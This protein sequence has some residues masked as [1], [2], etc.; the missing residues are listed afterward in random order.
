MREEQQLLDLAI[1]ADEHIMVVDAKGIIMRVNQPWMDFCIEHQI[2][3]ELWKAGS[4]YFSFLEKMGLKSELAVFQQILNNEKDEHRQLYPFHLKNG[5]TQW[6]SVKVRPIKKDNDQVQGIFFS[7]KPVT[8]HTMEPI[9]A[10]SVL[11]SMTDGFYLLDD[12][13]K[14]NYIND[15]AAQLLSCKRENVIGQ[16]VFEAF[17]EIRGSVF[18]KEYT[19]ALKFKSKAEIEEYY[20]PLDM[21]VSKKVYP[22]KRGGL[23]VYF[24]DITERKKA[25]EQLKEF[26]YYDYLTGV[27]NRRLIM[28]KASSYIEKGEKFSFFYI[29]LDNLKFVNALYTYSA[30]DTV[31]KSVAKKL[32]TLNS[33]KCEIG[34]L[35]GDEFCVLYRPFKEERLEGFAAR[36]KELFEEPFVLEGSQTVRINAS[37]GISCYPFDAKKMDELVSFSQ[38]AMYEAKKIHGSSSAFFRPW[39]RE[40]RERTSKIEEGLSGNLDAV[41][42]EFAVQPQIDGATGNLS[43]IEVLSRWHHPE[44]GFISP[45][46]F[47][48]IAEQT[49]TIASLTTHLLNKVFAKIKEWEKQFGWHLRTAINMTPSLLTNP[50]FFADFFELIERYGIQPELLEIEITEQAELTYSERTLENLQ[51]CK[52]KGI[53][54]AIDDF[55]TGFSMISYLT[56]FPINKIKIDKFFVQK[57]GVDIK[58]EALLKSLIHLGKS[59]GCELLAEGVERQEEVEFLTENSCTIFQGYLF[60]KPMRTIDFEEKYLVKPKVIIE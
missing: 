36:L 57:I 43:G 47:I 35:D 44:L 34:R 41:G 37:I 7:H 13:L 39:M 54:I 40:E 22:L 42:F 25:E 3:E 46:E 48:K 52:E 33:L 45:L 26:A 2:E 19:N 4:D 31:M 14:F 28:E 6:L 49:G 29:N 30:G 24:Q 38:T 15:I 56:H 17:P 60:D 18:D 5:E 9:T 55:G 59:I 11:E 32:K 27:P 50:A 16:E 58:S 53:S 21:W 10:E 23:A 12:Q 1:M 20:E 51:Y 8:L